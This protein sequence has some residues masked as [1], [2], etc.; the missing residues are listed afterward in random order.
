MVKNSHFETLYKI[1]SHNFCLDIKNVLEKLSIK[2]YPVGMGGVIALALIMIVVNTILQYL[3]EKNKK[4]L[5]LN[6]MGFFIIFITER[7]KKHLL[8]FYYS[9]IT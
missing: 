7:Y 2:E 6:L 5:F 1:L 3:M 8:I 9:T 4:S